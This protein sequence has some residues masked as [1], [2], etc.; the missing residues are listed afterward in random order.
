[1]DQVAVVLDHV[2][3]HS[4]WCEV[5]PACIEFRA[6]IMLLLIHVKRTARTEEASRCY[7]GCD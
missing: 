3:G 1:M 7:R 5:G 6:R 4:G 2:V